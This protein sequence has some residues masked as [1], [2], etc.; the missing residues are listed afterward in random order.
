MYDMPTWKNPGRPRRCNLSHLDEDYTWYYDLDSDDFEQ[1]VIKLKN[2]EKLT[3][4]DNDRYG[5]YVYTIIYIVLGNP[6]FSKK[7]HDER[8]ALF[9]QAVYEMLTGL[10]T[11]N[12]S[13]GKIYSYA[14]RIAYTSFCHYYTNRA[15]EARRNGEIVKHCNEEL[16]DYYEEYDDHKVPRH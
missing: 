8:A 4:V 10:T 6:K 14:Y 12:P 1:L 16:D 5:K 3:E 2:G 7:P 11:F 9:E 13:K 15:E